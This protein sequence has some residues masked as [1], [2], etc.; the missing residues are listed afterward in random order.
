MIT[1][2]A[3]NGTTA[4]RVAPGSD[5]L[6]DNRRA[7]KPGT[8]ARATTGFC[9]STNLAT[10]ERA[11]RR[12]RVDCAGGRVRGQIGVRSGSGTAR[13]PSFHDQVD[14]MGLA[15]RAGDSSRRLDHGF[16]RV[17]IRAR[18]AERGAAGLRRC[19]QPVRAG[20]PVC[21]AMLHQVPPRRLLGEHPRAGAG[22]P[23][24]GNRPATRARRLTS[25]R[26]AAGTV[27]W[28]AAS[29]RSPVAHTTDD[30]HAVTVNVPG[31]PDRQDHEFGLEY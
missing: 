24:R 13:Q 23:P 9:S 3:G 11:G 28:P 19:P 5:G 20:P 25:P 29:P 18:S 7:R 1:L 21:S 14:I 16:E 31:H 27:P 12:G 30:H 22:S 10:S 2:L 4:S 15:G 8:A 17:P 26:R 6:V